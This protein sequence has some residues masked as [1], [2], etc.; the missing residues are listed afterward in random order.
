MAVCQHACFVATPLV[1]WHRA[2]TTRLLW[3]GE[4]AEAALDRGFAALQVLPDAPHLKLQFASACTS[5]LP[6]ALR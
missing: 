6:L 5:C 2:R 3:Q 1:V 4:A